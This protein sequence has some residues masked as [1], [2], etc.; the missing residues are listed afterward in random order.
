MRV[1]SGGET[2]VDAGE[3]AARLRIGS[4]AAERE[5]AAGTL[6]AAAGVA[7]TPSGTSWTPSEVMVEPVA[8]TIV[9]TK[10]E[11]SCHSPE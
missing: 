9:T 2:S 8:L 7:R 10:E 4:G 6:A 3:V 11:A 1:A 5:G